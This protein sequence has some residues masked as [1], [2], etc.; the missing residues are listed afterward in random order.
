[1][2]NIRKVCDYLGKDVFGSILAF[3]G[4]AGS[5]TTSYRHSEE[6]VESKKPEIN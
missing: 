1:M 5:D 3:H 2:L 6:S 4:I